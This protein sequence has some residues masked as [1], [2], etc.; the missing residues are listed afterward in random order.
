LRG[1]GRGGRKSGR[2]HDREG[3]RTPLKKGNC[4][5]KKNQKKR[6][7]AQGSQGN[8]QKRPWLKE[9]P[10]APQEERVGEP[11]IWGQVKNANKNPQETKRLVKKKKSSQRSGL[12]EVA[13][14]KRKR[15]NLPRGPKDCNKK[16]S[17]VRRLA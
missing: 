5:R 1:R 3:L 7:N 10:K 11:G 17:A 4:E 2:S 12:G 6:K 9:N 14:E 15:Y 8:T 16:G 13:I